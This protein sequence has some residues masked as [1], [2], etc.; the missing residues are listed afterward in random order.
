VTREFLT[1]QGYQV[2]TAGSGEEALEL[3]QTMSSHVHLVILDLGM[4]GMG[5]QECLRRMLKLAPQVKIMISSGFA[6]ENHVQAAMKEGAAAYLVKPF[7]LTEFIT[8]IRGIL[9]C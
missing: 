3:I 4:P 8:K 2:F 9:D 1:G 7:H 5:G 6:S